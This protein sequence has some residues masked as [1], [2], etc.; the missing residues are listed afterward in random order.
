MSFTVIT[1]TSG[2]LPKVMADEYRLTVIPFYYHIGDQA[3][4]CE[5]IENF[6][7]DAYYRLLK[8][9][10]KVTTSQITPQQYAEYFR[11]ELEKGNDVIFV[12]MSSGISGSCDAA[13]V[14]GRMLAEDYPERKIGAVD[15]KGA[16]LGEGFVALEAARLRDQG[17]SFDEAM[18]KLENYS[19]RMCNIFTVDDLLYLR[20]GGRLSNAS[21]FLGTLLNIKPL[22]KGD[23]N[24]HITAFA[25]L[26]G[27]KKAIDGLVQRYEALVVRPEEQT[28]GI[29]QAACREDAAK[30]AEMIRNGPCPPK[31]ILE[32]DYEPVT[33]AH[34]GPGTLALF[35]LGGEDVRTAMDHAGEKDSLRRRAVEAVKDAAGAAFGKVS[36][37]KPVEAAKEAAEAVYEKVSQSKPVE[38]AK[39][40]A[41]AA[42]EKVV[43]SKAVGAAKE[44]AEAAYEKVAQSKAME[45]VKS[46]LGKDKENKE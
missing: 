1:D 36:Q 45:K 20:R 14:A 8:E 19:L 28:I 11:P 42:Y 18:E 34:V 33:C 6:D 15:T 10:T 37:S 41:E 44:A 27:R 26:R 32:V 39:E 46:Y 3:L 2:N 9:G 22:L 43:Q 5:A 23:E 31:E 12:S 17:L 24:G 25:K 13:R 16:A 40:A 38:A 4:C 29:V 35:F 21:A 30:L 7:S